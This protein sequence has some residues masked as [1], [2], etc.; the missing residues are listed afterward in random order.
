MAKCQ[1]QQSK[2]IEGIDINLGA[3]GATRCVTPGS[4]PNGSQDWLNR[5]IKNETGWD[6]PFLNVSSISVIGKDQ[7]Y[8]DLGKDCKKYD[9]Y[10]QASGKR[11]DVDPAI[12]A[13]IAMQ[14]SSCNADAGGS[15]PGLMQVPCENYP[16]GQCTNSVADNVDIAT[17]ELRQ[18]LDDS[19]GNI[20]KALGQYNGW[21]TKGNG[22]NG[23]NGLTQSYPCSEEGVKNGDPQNLDYVHQILNGWMLGLAVYSEDS[24]IGTYHCLG[25]CKKGNVC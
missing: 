6:P 3:K 20:L 23:N 12:L 4:G 24:W 5:G 8:A 19:K 9:E 11:Y 13:I 1:Q 21:F 16:E 14:E 25:K 10:F 18:H 15:T 22:F 17:K 7:F 2:C